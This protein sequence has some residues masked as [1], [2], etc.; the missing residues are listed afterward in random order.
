MKQTVSWNLGKLAFFLPI[1]LLLFVVGLTQTQIFQTA[2]QAFSNAILLDLLVTIPL[3]YFLII[4]NR[5]VPRITVLST[6]V[7]GIVVAS[8]IIPVESK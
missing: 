1:L 2:P 8:F 6:F 5:A 7:L 4:R 3:V